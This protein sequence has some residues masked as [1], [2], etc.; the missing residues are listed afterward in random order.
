[1]SKYQIS[2]GK[3][4]IEREEIINF[5]SKIFGRDYDDSR[6]IKEVIFD[7]EPSISPGNFIMAC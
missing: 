1:M 6:R 7:A 3:G 4:K 2:V 5:L